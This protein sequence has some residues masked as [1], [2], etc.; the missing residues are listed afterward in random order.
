M[1]YKVDKRLI[2]TR[3][4]LRNG[5]KGLAGC[6]DP[7]DSIAHLADDDPAVHVSAAAVLPAQLRQVQHPRM[8][9]MGLDRTAHLEAAAQLR[10]QAPMIVNKMLVRL[11]QRSRDEI[12]V[13][14]ALRNFRDMS[15]TV[16]RIRFPRA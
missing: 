5:E 8:K 15:W 10:E 16:T 9:I 2:L 11:E 14:L 7:E 4:I 1:F 12:D 6:A 3:I 13:D